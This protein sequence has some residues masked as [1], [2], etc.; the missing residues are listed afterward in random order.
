LIDLNDAVDA[1]VSLVSSNKPDLVTDLSKNNEPRDIH[2]I[3]G[4][5]LIDPR[6]YYAIMIYSPEFSLIPSASFRNVDRKETA[7]V[8]NIAIADYAF[9]Q[10]GDVNPY[11]AMARDFNTLIGRVA[12]LLVDDDLEPIL[13][14]GANN[15]YQI[16]ENSSIRVQ[17]LSGFVDDDTGTKALL[18]SVMQFNLRSC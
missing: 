18:Y 5:I 6:A 3:V 2:H 4:H 1:L 17:N 16:P 12:G 15:N 11:D 14:Q 9:V 7:H 8:F 13:I 10:K